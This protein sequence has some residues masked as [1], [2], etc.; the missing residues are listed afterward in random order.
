MIRICR[1]YT[2][3]LFVLFPCCCAAAA[4]AARSTSSSS[5]SLGIFFYHLSDCCLS[6]YFYI[7]LRIE[8][9]LFCCNRCNRY[10]V[11]DACGV[12]QSLRVQASLRLA[13]MQYWL[14]TDLPQVNN[15]KPLNAARDLS[16]ENNAV[17]C[18]MRSKEQM[19][20]G[21]TNGYWHFVISFI[22][23]IYGEWRGANASPY[24]TI[25]KSRHRYG[26]NEN[27]IWGFVMCGNR[28]YASNVHVEAFLLGHLMKNMHFYLRHAMCN[29]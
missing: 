23:W 19:E 22:D 15:N 28:D 17:E 24:A 11:R 2:N 27:E 25:M 5:I 13:S 26:L 16:P 14:A 9:I 10:D 7:L 29:K 12:V 21:S 8:S 6:Y 20:Y 4:A 3:F 1:L 18:V